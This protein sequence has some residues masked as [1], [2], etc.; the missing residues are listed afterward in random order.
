LNQDFSALASQTSTLLSVARSERF[1]AKSVPV[2]KQCQRIQQA[3]V[4]F[5]E[6]LGAACSSHNE[7]QAHLQVIQP[8]FAMPDDALEQSNVRFCVRLLSKSEGTR[9]GTPVWFIVRSIV[10]SI[11]MPK[12]YLGEAMV[13]VEEVDKLALALKRNPSPAGGFDSKRPR[14]KK[15]RTKTSELTFPMTLSST[16]TSSFKTCAQLRPNHQLSSN[17]ATSLP[18]FCIAQDLCVHLSGLC[19][20]PFNG[21]GTYF[22][23]L[24]KSSATHELY[25][26]SQ[27]DH[28]QGFVSLAELVG[29]MA[30]R[31]DVDQLDR[32]P[33]LECVRL[34]R[35]VAL[36]VLQFHSTPFLKPSWS[37]NDIVFYGLALH[38]HPS[39]SNNV[40]TAERIPDPYL[41]IKVNRKESHSTIIHQLST[42]LE[43]KP[44]RN[45][46]LFRLGVALLEIAY[47]DP[48][49]SIR[50]RSGTNIQTEF[51]IADY[52]SRTVG[53]MLGPRYAKIVRKCLGCDFGHDID[54][55]CEELRVAVHK[56]VVL[57][58]EGLV[59]DFERK[60]DISG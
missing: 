43:E 56:S 38:T 60:M 25:L 37:G 57:E 14:K 8:S 10:E 3:S 6:A 21:S 22:G 39:Q 34:A 28:A 18:N 50:H 58:L 52:Y 7:H 15:R 49:Q 26:E 31:R 42:N 47:Q 46:Y 35:N 53:S 11:P 45:F 19:Q 48:L 51:E 29:S 24:S 55:S 44:I 23:H 5:H 30:A 9:E 16:D 4:K 12:E 41:R 2:I 33:L 27:K 32:V 54:L 13:N 40:S 17:K 36:A 1:S 20:R 59:Q